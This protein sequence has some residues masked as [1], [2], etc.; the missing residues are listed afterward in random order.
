MKKRIPIFLLGLTALATATAQR[1]QQPLGR[2]VV[3][4]VRNAELGADLPVRMQIPFTM[5]TKLVR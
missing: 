5:F 1:L 4:V 3:A 2:G